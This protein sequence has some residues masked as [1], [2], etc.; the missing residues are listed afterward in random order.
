M[1]RVWQGL[2]KS[3][4]WNLRRVPWWDEQSFFWPICRGF[5]LVGTGAGLSAGVYWCGSALVNSRAPCGVRLSTAPREVKMKTI[6]IDVSEVTKED[7]LRFERMCERDSS[8]CLKWIGANTP[9]GYGRFKLKGRLLL[10][11]RFSFALRHNGIP[12]TG[13]IDHLCN[14]PWCVEPDHLRHTTYAFNTARGGSPVAANIR[15]VLETGRCVHGHPLSGTNLG[16]SK[17]GRYCRLCRRINE[18][19]HRS[20]PE[21]RRR[22]AMQARE[23]RLRK[24][25]A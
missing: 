13:V 4:G 25:A 22:R 7:R 1:S 20:D 24:K 19:A 18:N 14:N 9:A 6:P 23:Y 5:R 16:V 8:G 2:R 21:V 3:W 11:H 10:A 17:S 12:S 15:R